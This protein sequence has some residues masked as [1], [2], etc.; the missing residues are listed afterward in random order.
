MGNV[1]TSLLY[2]VNS[3]WWLHCKKNVLTVVLL[4]SSINEIMHT[5]N[6]IYLGRMDVTN[7][8]QFVL[9]FCYSLTVPQ[10]QMNSW[11]YLSDTC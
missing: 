5:R 4:E 10:D 11:P 2:W 3:D 8:Q 1:R 7:L 6:S 9:Y